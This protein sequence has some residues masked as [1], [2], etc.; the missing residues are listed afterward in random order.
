[1]REIHIDKAGTAVKGTLVNAGCLRE[2]HA[3]QI[4]AVYE[5]IVTD[6]YC[7]WENYADQVEAVRVSPLTDAYYLRKLYTN[8]D[9]AEL[10]IHE[11]LH[12]TVYLKNHSQFNE[13][14]AEFVGVEGARLYM[15]SV[16][17]NESPEDDDEKAALAR[18]DNE[19]FLAFIRNL[20]AE[21]DQV[22]NDQN[23][24]REEKLR[25]K[26]D[27]ITGA[28]ARFEETYDANYK[29]ENY[30]GF[31]G[32]QINNAYLE[33]YRLYHERSSWF[34]DLYEKS[35]NSLQAYIAAAK[36]LKGKDDPRTEFERTLGIASGAP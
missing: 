22:Y 27:I 7:L 2:I 15:E 3:N 6:A 26:A 5:C 4:G 1:M 21:L 36:T 11:L 32:M 29:T 35:G 14:L 28:Q 31:S 34:K 18:T 8:R 23:L 16:S 12:A 13:E 30:R 9:L 33:L 10:I 20:I 17:G 24:S 25:C 19:F